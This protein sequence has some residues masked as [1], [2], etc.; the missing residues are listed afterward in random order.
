MK[1]NPFKKIFL[2][3]ALLM[4]IAHVS[5][6]DLIGTR[7]DVQGTRF[8]DQMWLFSVASC[9]YNF[10]NGWDGYKMFGTSMAPQLFAVEPDGYYQV[11]S[12]PDVNN[13]YLGF[14]AGVDSAYTF[15]F[16]HQ[17]L[18]NRYQMLYLIDSVS[19]KVVDIY[20]T[21]SK[22]NFT[23][24]PTLA[25]IR[26]FKIVTSKPIDLNQSGS[27]ITNVDQVKSSSNNLKIYYAEK[28][29]YIENAAHKKGKMMLFNAQT[30]REFKTVDFNADGTTIIPADVP[31][32]IYVVNGKTL[33]E[34]I[35]E[36]IVI[37]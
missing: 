26:R 25:P 17:N 28:N 7:I 20:T 27:M 21:G 18:S 2:K 34:N 36:K 6:Q 11:A 9:T 4:I 12:I 15:T 22:Y 19:N 13:T 1:T 8:S 24:Q 30:G 23:A 16:T 5:A 37:H 35:S 31:G 14:S 33:S 10:D 29:I 32:G 3:L